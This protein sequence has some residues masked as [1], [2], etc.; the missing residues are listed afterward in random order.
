MINA[1]KNDG[2]DPD[3]VHKKYPND[4]FNPF[5]NHLYKVLPIY[6]EELRRRNAC[7]FGDMLSIPLKLFEE[8]KEILQRWQ[9]RY[10]V[11][12]VDEYQDTNPVQ[13]KLLKLLKEYYPEEFCVVGDERSSSS[14]LARADIS[15]IL[16]FEKDFPG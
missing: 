2:L 13:Y 12:L 6:E 9:A 10:P 14:S 3:E 8:N 15:N 1:L 5:V 7:D 4:S 16:N 11:V